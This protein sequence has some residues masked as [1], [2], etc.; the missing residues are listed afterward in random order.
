MLFITYILS[1]TKAEINVKTTIFLFFRN[2]WLHVLIPSKPTLYYL[3]VYTRAFTLVVA[4]R[5]FSL[6]VIHRLRITVASF[7]AEH[8][9]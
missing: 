6:V 2:S 9:L 5:G 7:L 4:S 3:Y 8:G 1:N